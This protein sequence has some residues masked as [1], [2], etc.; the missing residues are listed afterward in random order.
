M[1]EDGHPMRHMRGL[2]KAINTNVMFCNPAANDVKFTAKGNGYTEMVFF[3]LLEEKKICKP[4]KEYKF[5]QSRKWRFDYAFPREKI[6]VEVEGGVWIRGRHNSPRGYINDME[7]YN[8]AAILGW[9]VLRFTPDQLIK[10]RTID[11]LEYLL[12]NRKDKVCN[13]WL[14]QKK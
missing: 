11:V 13:Y 2:F 1:A 4:D 7:K 3:A 5:C 14:M 9:R 12:N 10:S 8:T 6:A